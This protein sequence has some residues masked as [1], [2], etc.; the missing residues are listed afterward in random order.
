MVGRLNYFDTSY[1]VAL[2]VEEQ[3]SAKIAGF[4]ATLDTG[5]LVT[6]HWTF[7]EF[8]SM[9]AREV[10][11]Q[12]LTR[13]DAIFL[14]DR[15]DQL[16][17][18]SFSLLVPTTDDYATATAY[19]GTFETGLRGPDAMHL[20]IAGNHNATA[21]LSLDKKMIKAGHLLGLPTSTGLPLP[22]YH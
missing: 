10:R 16:I 17:R 14:R 4:V 5:S 22:D 2:V 13:E 20:A 1:L 19:V 8:G 6:S 3:H 11:K 21:I 12:A 15:F 9:L 7:V 18:G